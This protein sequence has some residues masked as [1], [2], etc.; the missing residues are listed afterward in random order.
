MIFEEEYSTECG[1]VIADSALGLA[2]SKERASE[3]ASDDWGAIWLIANAGVPEL[4][5][6]D[7]NGFKEKLHLAKFTTDSKDDHCLSPWFC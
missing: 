5:L 4:F 1:V 3:S 6:V 7:A 2:I